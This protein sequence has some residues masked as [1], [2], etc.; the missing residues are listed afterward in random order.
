MTAP[1]TV[2]C[3]SPEDDEGKTTEERIIHAL[4]M[5]SLYLAEQISNPEN[6][7]F[8][9]KERMEVHKQ[10]RDWAVTRR[11]LTAGDDPEGG[12]ALTAI[13]RALDA[14]SEVGKVPPPKPAKK[15]KGGRP[16]RVETLMKDANAEWHRNHAPDNAELMKLG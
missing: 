12:E 5:A 15:P 2:K 7:E 6:S 10:L 11:R 13:K 16:T 9:L 4:D 8:S 3:W 14:L 1:E